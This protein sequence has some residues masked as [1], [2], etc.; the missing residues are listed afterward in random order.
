MSLE[1]G[2]HVNTVTLDA[3]HDSVAPDEHLTKVVATAFSNDVPGS[4]KLSSAS[5]GSEKLVDPLRSGNGIVGRDV[6]VDGL[7]VAQS[8]VG[9]HEFPRGT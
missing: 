7:E 1:D 5:C 3:V 2:E 8:A 6:V 4:W 9:P